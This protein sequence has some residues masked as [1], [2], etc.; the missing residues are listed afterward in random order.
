MTATRS[1]RAGFTLLEVMIAVALSATI[2]LVL[3]VLFDASA[4]V[5]VLARQQDATSQTLAVFDG[6][7]LDDLRSINVSN[8]TNEAF[9]FSGRQAT[10]G[11]EPFL[12]FPTGVS[13]E[14]GLP[15]PSCTVRRVEY[16]VVEHPHGNGL[17]VV[18]S[19]MPWP[20]VDGD[21]EDVDHVL[22]EGVERFKVEYYNE[23]ADQFVSVWGSGNGTRLPDAVRF[24]LA[25]RNESGDVVERSLVYTVSGAGL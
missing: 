20:G 24:A 9:H 23:K 1:A 17:A 6:I 14:T 25:V 15:Y 3:F 8:A 16:S 11:D 10:P 19:E 22:L 13:L 12:A 21:W 4:D 7:V 2:S 5:A 18:R